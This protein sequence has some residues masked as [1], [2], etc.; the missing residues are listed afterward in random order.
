[1]FDIRGIRA[2][3]E[4]VGNHVA[5]LPTNNTI[6]LNV[7]FDLIPLISLLIGFVDVGF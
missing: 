1:M 3:W 5:R 4:I 2:K 6:P 7:R